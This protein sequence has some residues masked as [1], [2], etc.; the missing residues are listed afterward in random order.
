[1][2][3]QEIN[4]KD[5]RLEEP[6]KRQMAM[7]SKRGPFSGRTVEGE[8][9]GQAFFQ[10]GENGPMRAS[11]YGEDVAKEWFRTD[12]RIAKKHEHDKII[13]VTGREGYGKSTLALQL[14]LAVDEDLSVDQIIFNRDRLE[15]RLRVAD[16]GEVL[17]VDEA[18]I[19]MF[20]QEWWDEMQRQIIKRLVSGR[21]KGLRIFFVSPHLKMLNNQIRNRRLDQWFYCHAIGR[22][23]RG[24]AH[25]REAIEN[26]YKMDVFWEPRMGL[27]FSGLEGDL[28]NK[29]TE[30]KNNF[31]DAVYEGEAEAGDE[32]DIERCKM[33][34]KLGK[35]GK[36]SQEIA[37]FL[38]IGASRV[39][40]YMSRLKNNDQLREKIE[41]A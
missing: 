5:E 36:S 11:I 40:D 12:C 37:N 38:T 2:E 13:A 16:P 28:W 32:A 23:G 3:T 34:C 8:Y 15:D 6:E 10:E 22:Y 26:K 9:H 25:L 1:M 31:V 19:S 39:R 30:K 33:I 27:K 14:A 17:I 21:V 41:S 7:P 18:G 20:S 24:E 29:Y 35:E 4:E